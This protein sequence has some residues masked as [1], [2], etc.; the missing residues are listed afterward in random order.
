[1]TSKSHASWFGVRNASFAYGEYPVLRSM[2]LAIAPGQIHALVGMHNSGKSTLCSLLAGRHFHPWE[3]GEGK[4]VG[5]YVLAHLE[6]AR[7]ALAAGDAKAALGHLETSKTYPHNLGEGK[8]PGA[9][10]NRTDYLI[11]LAYELLGDADAARRAFER[12]AAG[13]AEPAG[14][15]YYNDQPADSIYYQGLAWQK[16]GNRFEARKRFYKL[17]D[18]GEKHVQDAMRIDYFAVS[19]P[20]FLV[21]EEDL[22][23]KNQTYCRY[24]MGLGL[25]GLGETEAGEAALAVA[26]GLDPNHQGVLF[27][28]R[29]R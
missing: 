18:Y 13:G 12:A 8:L 25:L 9:V 7:K 27:A 16:L 6:L 4:S 20:D 1:M 14:V 3:G 11:G 2:D 24:L 17:H 21:F 19:L 26:A 10:E 22:D 28:W 23:K 5:Q 29:E 15:M